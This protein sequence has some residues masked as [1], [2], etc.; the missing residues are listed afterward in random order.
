MT[1]KELSEKEIQECEEVIIHDFGNNLKMSLKKIIDNTS[2]RLDLERELF[3]GCC[4]LQIDTLPIPIQDGFNNNFDK[5]KRA[6]Q[7]L[8]DMRLDKKK[9]RPSDD[10]WGIIEFRIDPK[11]I[12][13]S[14]LSFLLDKSFPELIFEIFDDDEKL[15]IIFLD[16]YIPYTF[17]DL[18]FPFLILPF[19]YEINSKLAEVWSV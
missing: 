17:Y 5:R 11:K 9:V 2:D 19:K 14:P 16:A 3:I 12:N 8:L 10:F 6:D 1:G 13:Y 15:L 18:T 4:K 7:V